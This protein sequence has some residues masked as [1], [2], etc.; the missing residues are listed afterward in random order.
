MSDSIHLLLIRW[1][2][3]VQRGIDSN[4]YSGNSTIARLI[5]LGPDGAAIRSGAATTPNYWPDQDI[6]AINMAISS[7]DV[8]HRNAI[9]LTYILKCSLSEG[10][11]NQG[12]TKDIYRH[13]LGSAVAQLRQWL[14]QMP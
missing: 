5:E 2:E 9:I 7:L 6:V 11:K 13:R 12:I 1:A 4:S 8:E 3:H 10:G 14:S